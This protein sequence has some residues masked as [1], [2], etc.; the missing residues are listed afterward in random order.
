MKAWFCTNH[1]PWSITTLWDL[2]LQADTQL[3][4]PNLSHLV[5]QLYCWSWF[6]FEVANLSW[7]L[8]THCRMLDTFIIKGSIECYLVVS[9]NWAFFSVY[10]KRCWPSFFSLGSLM[11]VSP[12][13]WKTTGGKSQLFNAFWDCHLGGSAESHWSSLSSCESLRSHRSSMSELLWNRS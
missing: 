2:I 12:I 10:V 4:D 13:I 3:T 8:A 11:T 7:D 1:T 6:A 5:C 9:C